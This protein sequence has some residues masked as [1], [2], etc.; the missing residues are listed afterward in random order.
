MLA[1]RIFHARSVESCV[2]CH[3][4]H[5]L[6]VAKDTCT[7]CHEN[8]TPDDIRLSRL[9]FDGSGDLEKGIR[10]DIV[11]NAQRLSDF[12]GE[13]SAQVAGTPIIYD[14]HS[15]PYFFTDA[16]ADGRIDAVDGRSVAYAAWTPRQLRAAYNWKFVT[17][18]AGAFA[19]NPHYMLALLY[20][21]IED[22]AAPLDQEIADWGLQLP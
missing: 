20:D 13:C 11:A 16:N 9:S 1:K 18:D 19:H 8:G 3:D 12:M 4:P 14:A 2:S 10:A 22:L 21:S 7:T 5:S 17:A 15:Y 6:Q